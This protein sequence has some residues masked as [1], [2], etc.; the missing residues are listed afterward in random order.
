MKIDNRYT[1]ELTK[2]AA[3]G[4][5]KELRQTQCHSRQTRGG[6]A[7]E[8]FGK[9]VAR[10]VVEAQG[11]HYCSSFSGPEAEVPIHADNLMIICDCCIPFRPQSKMDRQL[12]SGHHHPNYVTSYCH[13]HAA[14][15]LD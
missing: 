10:L 4:G 3:A 6:K 5:V 15:I 13:L 8:N 9:F 11:S 1:E 12:S 14:C 2:A 7:Q